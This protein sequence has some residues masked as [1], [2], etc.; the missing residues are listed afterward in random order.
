M[1]KDFTSALSTYKEALEIDGGHVMVLNSIAYIYLKL[2][3]EQESLQYAHRA[4][5]QDVDYTP[6]LINLGIAY[7]KT[8]NAGAAEYYLDRAF[9]LEPDNKQAIFNLALL[10]EKKKSYDYAAD[11]FLKLIR[12]GDS[13]G[14]L[15]LART[16]EMQGKNREALKVYKNA[17]LKGPF[18]QKT[19]R[20]IRQRIMM[21]QNEGEG[22]DI[23]R[24]T[25]PAEEATQ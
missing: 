13:S 1:R 8:G 10:H 6:A 23:V 4:E 22:T 14:T 9:R 11:F 17:A 21:L 20:Q 2:G 7:A 24:P 12:L 18:D 19:K 15:G 3:L 16:Y 25:G 5:E